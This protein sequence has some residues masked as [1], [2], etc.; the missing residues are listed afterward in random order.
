MIF[1]LISDVQKRQLVL[2]VDCLSKSV[3][4]D[5]Q[6]INIFVQERHA[7]LYIHSLKLILLQF[8]LC[9]IKVKIAKNV[10]SYKMF[11]LQHSTI[12]NPSL[13]AYRSAG[14]YFLPVQGNNILNFKVNYI[15][16]VFLTNFARNIC[17]IINV[18]TVFNSYRANI[19]RPFCGDIKPLIFVCMSF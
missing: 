6:T 9:N 3:T 2:P 10:C 5:Q 18:T 1:T 12:I 4:H 8:L 16:L 13:Q 17:D 15:C 19:E 11:L 14:L 7:E